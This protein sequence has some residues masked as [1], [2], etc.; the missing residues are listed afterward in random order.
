[1]S[2]GRVTAREITDPRRFILRTGGSVWG[3]LSGVVEDQI[4]FR[5]IKACEIDAEI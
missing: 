2:P 5:K 4:D 1:M 3:A